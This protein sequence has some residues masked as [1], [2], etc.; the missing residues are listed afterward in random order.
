MRKEPV[1]KN[2]I[3]YVGLDVHKDLIAV[4]VC[5]EDGSVTSLGNLP[6]EP[7]AV[8][9]LMGKLGPVHK[10]RVCYEA[11]PCGYVLY[12]QLCKLG[13]DCIVVAPSLIPQR[14]GDRV[15][16]DRK[17]AVKQARL[18]RNGDLTAVFVPDA[19]HLALRELVRAREAALKDQK[20]AR[21]RLKLMLLRWGIKPDQAY[22]AWS[23]GYL[24]WVGTIRRVTS[25][26][27]YTLDDAVAQVL[28]QTAR[29]KELEQTL[30]QAVEQAPPKLRAV[31][32][33]LQSLVGVKVLTA[34]TV[35]VEAGDLTRFQKAPQLFSY[36][37]MVPSEYSSGGPKGQRRGSLTKA[38]NAHLRR[39]VVEAG[40]SYSRPCRSDGPVAKRRRGQDPV[41]VQLAHQAQK[42][43]RQR[44]L[45]FLSNQ[46]EP[47]KAVTAVARELLGFMWGIAKRVEATAG[48]QEAMG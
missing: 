32:T 15:K 21:A 14:P 46:M 3:R 48:T 36:A 41:V 11:G 6:N 26:E 35:A 2:S 9:R 28:H 22:G 37:G 4:A 12:W 23:A 31:I 20:R 10:L 44:Y 24:C 34:T 38:G 5:E 33:A 43:L 19:E 7:A 29:L 40:W 18:L 30:S 25:A 13:I 45:H 39:V 42:R 8:A 16:T 17:D 1:V 47:A 27:Q